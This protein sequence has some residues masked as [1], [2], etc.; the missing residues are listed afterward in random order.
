MTAATFATTG[1]ETT[2]SH[3]RRMAAWLAKRT[4][5]HATVR[6]LGLPVAYTDEETRPFE[7]L[8]YEGWTLF[9]GQV[10]HWH[11][12]KVAL[13]RHGWPILV[14][15]H[16]DGRN[17]MAA[18]FG[19]IKRRRFGFEHMVSHRPLQKGDAR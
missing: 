9:G 13:N 17:R 2:T 4:A 11:C 16:P 19:G 5:A 7:A 8:M 3:E 18:C 6:A 10:T 14:P 1:R 15:C 12:C